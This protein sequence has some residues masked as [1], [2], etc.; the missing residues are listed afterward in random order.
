MNSVAK[1]GTTGT[2][3]SDA[4][5]ATTLRY[6]REQSTSITFGAQADWPCDNWYFFDRGIS[7]PALRKVLDHWTGPGEVEFISSAYGIEA[8]W[9]AEP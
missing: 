8:T 5:R 7:Q 6:F 3:Y 9:K 4:V 2:S 1:T